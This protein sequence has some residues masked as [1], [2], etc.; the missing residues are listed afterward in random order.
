MQSWW[1]FDPWKLL[2]IAADIY[3]NFGNSGF[4]DLLAID[5]E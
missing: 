3:D 4:G 5:T 2:V 1:I